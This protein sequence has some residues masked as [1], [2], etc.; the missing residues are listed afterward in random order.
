MMVKQLLFYSSFTILLVTTC[1]CIPSL[2]FILP[3]TVLKD[4]G[5]QSF[6]NS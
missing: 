5:S 1:S 2:A 4:I 6:T 3:A